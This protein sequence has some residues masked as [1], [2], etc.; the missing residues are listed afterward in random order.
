[1]D[2]PIPEAEAMRRYLLKQGIPEER[3]LPEPRAENTFQN[4]AFSR[5]IIQ[6]VNP[7]GKPLFVTTNYHV[8]RSGVWAAEAG[9]PSEGIG[10]RTV[11]WFWPNAFMRETVGLLLNRWWQELLFLLMLIAF[12]ILLSLA[13][14]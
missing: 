7:L 14:G 1:M 2:E 12:L 10:S 5:E 13:I 4:M 3:I 11:W 8:F 6:Q 9:I